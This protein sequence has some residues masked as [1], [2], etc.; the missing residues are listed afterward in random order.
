MPSPWE[1]RC[2]ECRCFISVTTS[3]EYA[4]ENNASPARVSM[5]YGAVEHRVCD[6]ST[7]G[8]ISEAAKLFQTVNRNQQPVLL[9]GFAEQLGWGASHRWSDPIYLRSILDHA[10][11]H[12]KTVTLASRD[13]KSYEQLVSRRANFAPGKF[14]LGSDHD[15]TEELY[16]PLEEKL[17]WANGVDR[18]FSRA[19][20]EVVVITEKTQTLSS[21]I[22][23]Q[24]NKNR[25]C[26]MKSDMRPSLRVH[27]RKFPDD[28]FFGSSDD[29]QTSHRANKTTEGFRDALA[30]VWVGQKGACTS[31]HFDLCH[32][33]VAQVFGCKLVTLYPPS[34]SQFL[35]PYKASEGIIRCSQLDQ[36]LMDSRC[37][38]Q[39]AKHP[40]SK[41]AK[42]YRVTINPGDALYIPPFWWHHVEALTVNCSVLLPFE[43]SEQ[44]QK[45]CDRPWVKEDWGRA[46]SE[47]KSAG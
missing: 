43:L 39:A 47:A 27:L 11:D 45:N 38:T 17:S 33:L 16:Q 36:V 2:V 4:S 32:G 40:D 42:G 18:V 46:V 5:I 22:K 13:F 1:L 31:L 10:P 28:A 29:R 6:W 25:C 7:V 35:S 41:S 26:Y 12:L 30:K 20:S 23:K 9:N 15:S 14:R 34:E 24:N 44:E 19:G 3:Y 8:S 37:Q 21:K